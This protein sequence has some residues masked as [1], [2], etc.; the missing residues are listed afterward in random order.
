MLMRSNHRRVEQHRF[1]VRRLQSSHHLFP[2]PRL[3]PSIEPLKHRIPITKSLRK[4]APR[5]PRSCDPDHCIHKPSIVLGLP[6]RIS[7]T[8]WQQVL[9][10]HPFV[11]REF[12]TSHR[13]ASLPNG[14]T[15]L[16]EHRSTSNPRNHAR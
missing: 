12:V 15:N 10:S 2:H 6:S 16:S 3:R 1:Q 9:Y 13:V 14:K 11:I 8:S 4:V 5:S 7:I